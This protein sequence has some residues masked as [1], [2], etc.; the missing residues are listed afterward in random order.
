MD[1]LEMT[2]LQSIWIRKTTV[3]A[4]EARVFGSSTLFGCFRKLF[5]SDDVPI[6]T[7]MAIDQSILFWW[8]LKHSFFSSSF[9]SRMMIDYKRQQQWGLQVE[10]LNVYVIQMP[11]KQRPCN[12]GWEQI[13]DK[14]AARLLDRLRCTRVYYIISTHRMIDS[15]NNKNM[16]C[17]WVFGRPLSSKLMKKTR[18]GSVFI[19]L[20]ITSVI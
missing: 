4:A 9:S 7:F 16:C 5:H 2:F 14:C 10:L 20:R 15:H 18:F 17:R 3:S 1:W 12:T 8:S 19:C 11:D 13:F 6:F